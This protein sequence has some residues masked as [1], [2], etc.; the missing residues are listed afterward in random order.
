MLR[1]HQDV[2]TSTSVR[3]TYLRRVCN[4]SLARKQNWPT[5]DVVAKY[6]WLL[7]RDKLMWGDAEFW[8]ISRRSDWLTWGV[9]V[10]IFIIKSNLIYTN[11]NPKLQN[12]KKSKVAS[13]RKTISLVAKR[14]SI[15]VSGEQHSH[16]IP[17]QH[18]G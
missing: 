9:S 2:A 8:Q 3:R 18:R 17:L 6:Q 11:N 10:I 1:R 7:K 4:I 14:V 15:T 5:W 13:K 12:F 16:N